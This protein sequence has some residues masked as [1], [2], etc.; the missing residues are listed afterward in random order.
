VRRLGVAIA[1][2]LLA[3]G[4]GSAKSSGPPPQSVAA[5]CGSFADA[6][7]STPVWLHTSDKVKLYAAAVDAGDTTV[8]L[9]HE[10]P[11]DVCGW[12][13]T[14]QWL[15]AHGIGSLAFDFRTFGDSESPPLAIST[16]VRPD[17]QAAIDEA[18]KRGAKRVIVMGASFGGASMLASGPQL[19]GVDGMVNLSGELRLPAWHLDG[20]DAVPRLHT[21]IFIVASAEDG[22]FNATDARLLYRRTGSTDKQ[23]VVFPG[24]LHGWDLLD[25]N[26][27][28]RARVLAWLKR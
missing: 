25:R 18:R 28:A 17:L 1:V 24:V 13:P 12:V 20:I 7:H 2:A 22:L 14:M 5:V 10:S 3:A 4:C 15:K 6:L 16:H 23:L 26:P 9:A 27:R 11:G 8:V 19:E 21:P